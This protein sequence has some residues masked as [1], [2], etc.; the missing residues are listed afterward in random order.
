VFLAATEK[1][2]ELQAGIKL[3]GDEDTYKWAHFRGGNFS[4]GASVAWL[5]RADGRK[6]SSLHFVF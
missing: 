1:S 4:F 2:T 6:F 3:V 5:C